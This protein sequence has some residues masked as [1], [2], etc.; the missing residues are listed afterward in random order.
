ML[1]SD[2]ESVAQALRD[3]KCDVTIHVPARM[4]HYR[5]QYTPFSPEAEEATAQMRAWLRKKM[6]S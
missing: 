2:A 5:A 6:S 3:A 4:P 1:L